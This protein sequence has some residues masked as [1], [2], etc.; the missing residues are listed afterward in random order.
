MAR[1]KRSNNPDGRPSRRLGEAAVLVRLPEALR[2]R[3]QEHAE[4]LGLSES[5]W[6]RQAALMRL[7]SSP[8][9]VGVPEAEV[10]AVS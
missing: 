7:R 4:L 1:R 5:A 8:D 3:V 9:D 6:W 10:E 2:E